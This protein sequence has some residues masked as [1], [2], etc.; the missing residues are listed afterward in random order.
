MALNAASHNIRTPIA[1]MLMGRPDCKLTFRPAGEKTGPV[2]GQPPP[3]SD[4]SSRDILHAAN[5]DATGQSA[6]GKDGGDKDAGKKVK[7]EKELAKERAKAEKMKKFAEKKAKQDA[8][9]AAAKPKENK[10]KA[11]VKKEQPVYVEETPKGQKKLLKSLDDDFHKAYNPKVVE[12]AW[13]DWWEKE[14][15]FQPE[16]GPD[17]KVK[18]E[19]Y[20]VIPI[21]PPNVTGAL[22]CGH[23]LATALQDT[24]IRWNRMKG[25]TVLYLPGCDHAGISTQSVVENMLW[26]REKKTRHDLGRQALVERI[27]E[28]KGEYHARIKTVLHRLAGSFDWTR[29]AFVGSLL[30]IFHKRVLIAVQK[31]PW[32]RIS[33]PL[34]QK[35]S[36]SFMKKV[37]STA[38]IVS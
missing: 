14:G 33:A 38:R 26:R 15:F 27:W 28:W 30:S 12:S 31:R 9:A 17:G 21:P 29:E 2:T 25:L 37:T 7:S 19:G 13:A 8:A 11:E 1:S 5:N 35:R 10:K 23:A 4:E 32:T 16:F 3:V 34:S 20:F 24:L 6:P 22:H 36:S 18:P